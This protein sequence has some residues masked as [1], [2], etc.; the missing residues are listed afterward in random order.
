MVLPTSVNYKREDLKTS[1][2]I[3]MMFTKRLVWYIRVNIS[4]KRDTN[5]NKKWKRR[6]Y[7]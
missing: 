2:S 6:A 5:R 7:T 4:Y 3:N 1:K